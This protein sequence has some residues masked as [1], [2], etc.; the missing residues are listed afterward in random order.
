[1]A[2]EVLA[3]DHLNEVGDVEAFMDVPADRPGEFITVERV[4]GPEG[5]ILGAPLLAVQVWAGARWRAAE[6]AK[7]YSDII[8][9]METLPWVGRVAISSVTNFPDPDS[10]TARYQLTVELVTQ[11]D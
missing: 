6:L 5:R 4:G 2:V 8:R 7:T 10:R 11:L 3:V 9:R 1:M